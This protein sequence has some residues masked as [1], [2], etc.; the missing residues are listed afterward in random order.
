MQRTPD[1][2]T[3]LQ[4]YVQVILSEKHRNLWKFNEIYI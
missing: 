1:G 2:A 4:C 3:E